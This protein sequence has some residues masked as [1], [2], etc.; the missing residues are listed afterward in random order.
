M[1]EPAV[2]WERRYAAGR[3]LNVYP[4]DVVVTLTARY[5][6]G[7][8][9]RGL[10]VL[11]LG[12]GAGNHALFFARLGFDV[13]CVDVSATA[14]EV[15][16]TR[17]EAEGLT[18]AFH[19]MTFDAVAS[20]GRFDLVLDRGS[21][22]YEPF[23]RLRS[24]VIPAVRECLAPDGLLFSCLLSTEHPAADQP[25][26]VETSDR[27]GGIPLTILDRE[28]VYELFKPLSIVQLYHLALTQLHVAP[29]EPALGED[30]EFVVVCRRDA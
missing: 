17:F 10:R 14:H 13:T 12:S 24:V 30:G 23:D 27:D 18:A 19:V 2:A 5:F 16:R 25:R 4:F 22:Y 29:G 20:L 28:A 21:L 26:D 1:D 8:D 7:R 11:D 9:C 6:G 15:A 3:A